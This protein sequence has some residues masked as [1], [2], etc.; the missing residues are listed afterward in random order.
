MSFIELNDDAMFLEY[1]QGAGQPVFETGWGALHHGA[2]GRFELYHFDGCYFASLSCDWCGKRVGPFKNPF[3][4]AER[5]A[6]DFRI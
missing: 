6:G 4:A 1:L 2:S 3:E 5:F